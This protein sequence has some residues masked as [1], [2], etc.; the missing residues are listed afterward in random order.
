ML[1]KAH[2]FRCQKSTDQPREMAVIRGI[3]LSILVLRGL[4]NTIVFS[5][6]LLIVGLLI[7]SLVVTSTSPILS[8]HTDLVEVDIGGVLVVIGHQVVDVSLSLGEFILI[9]SLVAVPVQESL[10]LVHPE[11]LL[12]DSLKQL[13][14]GGGVSNE[15]CSNLRGLRR[16]RTERSLDIIGDEVDEEILVALAVLEHLILDFLNTAVTAE[17]SATSEVLA[18]P[19]VD[20]SHKVATIKNLLSDLRYRNTVEGTGRLG[21]QW[22][23]ANSEEVEAVE[24]HQVDSQLTK[25]AV[26]LTRVTQ[27]GGD[28]RHNLSNQ[29]VE[30]IVGGLGN[31]Q[32]L[33]ED[34]VESLVIQA[35]SLVGSFNKLAQRQHGVVWL[36]NS[37]GVTRRKDGVGRNHAIAVLITEAVDEQSS[38]TRTSSTTERVG[39]LEALEIVSVLSFTANDLHNL[40]LDLGTLGIEAL[41]PVVT[42]TRERI[43]EVVRT[44]EASQGTR[45]DVVN[46]GRLEVNHDSTGDVTVRRL[47][48]VHVELFL[49]GLR[50]RRRRF[51]VAVGV[52]TVFLANSIPEGTTNL[53]TT[54]SCRNVD[55]FT[56][57]HSLIL[58]GLSFDNFGGVVNDVKNG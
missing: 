46:G 12:V 27:R 45:A 13:S 21:H 54:L 3:N 39:E 36:D 52:N 26:E 16:N 51:A 24:W 32:G 42:R 25:I 31:L 43:D 48:V 10:A 41:G 49:G 15:S 33:L 38:E 23:V 44:E 20:T 6:C 19:G 17:E 30:I 8:L 9:H 53:V 7:V 11:E 22:S 18:F 29:T 37:V 28:T 1:V 47:R 4:H 58:S 14:N 40:L 35:E 34:V 5:I 57:F 50:T 2:N 55:D 56:H